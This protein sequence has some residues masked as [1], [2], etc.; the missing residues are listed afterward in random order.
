MHACNFKTKD[1][2]TDVH[3]ISCSVPLPCHAVFRILTTTVRYFVR[4]PL[5]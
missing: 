1:S 3:E 2:V 5:D 4:S